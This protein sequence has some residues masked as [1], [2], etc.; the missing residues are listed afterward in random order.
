MLPN[1]LVK[2]CALLAAPRVAELVIT[3][4]CLK[5]ACVRVTVRVREQIGSGNKSNEILLWLLS[6]L[7]NIS[8]KE[9]I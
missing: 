8:K 2:L 7:K 1:R 3:Q 9:N 4:R 6:I 5:V